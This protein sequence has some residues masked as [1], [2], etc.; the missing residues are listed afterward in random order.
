M[1]WAWI[2]EGNGFSV[3]HLPTRFGQLDF[4]IQATSADTIHVEIRGDLTLPPGGLTIVPPLPDGKQIV[5]VEPQC[6]THA[7]IDPKGSSVAVTSLPF[8]A[9]LRLEK[10][11]VLA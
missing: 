1:P 7:P 11:T 5:A 3:S 4:R 8:A 6:G 2:S 10:R 9:D